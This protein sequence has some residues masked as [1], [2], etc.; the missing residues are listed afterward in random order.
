MTGRR[1][2]K[3]AFRVNQENA[4]SGGAFQ[5]LESQA[6]ESAGGKIQP[7]QKPEKQYCQY[8]HDNEKQPAK[9]PDLPLVL[10]KPAFSSMRVH[11]NCHQIKHS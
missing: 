2:S 6:I 5:A 7:V 10:R 9:K 11:N 3:L 8:N 1:I 4:E